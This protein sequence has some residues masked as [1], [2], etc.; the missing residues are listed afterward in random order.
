MSLGVRIQEFLSVRKRASELGMLRDLVAPSAGLRLL[1]V[2]GGAGGVGGLRRAGHVASPGQAP[3]RARR[4]PAGYG[5]ARPRPGLR[6][7]SAWGPPG[8]GAVPPGGGPGGPAVL[9]RKRP[10][11]PW[12]APAVKN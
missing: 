8:G 5:A 7:F 6:G 4:E 10:P 3:T 9:E 1:D 11:P 2:G 12:W